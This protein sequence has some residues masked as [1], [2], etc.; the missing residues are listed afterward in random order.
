VEVGA[1]LAAL[2]AAGKIKADY[3]DLRVIGDNAGE[4]DRIIDPAAGPAPPAITF[5][6]AHPL[7][8]GTST[9]DYAFY[10]GNPGAGA[11]PAAGSSV[12]TIYDDFTAGIAPIWS[13]NDAP[14]TTAGQLILR[15]NHTDAIATTS[16]T[17]KLP[18]TSAVELIARVVVPTSDPTV[19][20]DGTFYYWFGYQK[21]GEFTPVS[22]PWVV[23]IARGKSE[24]GAEQKSPVGCESGCEPPTGSQDAAAH[25]FAIQRDPTQTRFYRDAAAPVVQDVM[26]TEDYAVMVRNFMAT[27]DLQV[28][29]VRARARVTPDPTVVIAS[30]ETLP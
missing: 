3:S 20:T 2:G 15:A 19:Q 29:Y 25:Y 22:D 1:T 24:I 7:A 16:A 13:R 8:A 5:A 21:T 17:D 26:N 30:E 4:R 6:L 23:W 27:S 28:D 9:L 14:T 12:F 18:I 10:Y 11:A